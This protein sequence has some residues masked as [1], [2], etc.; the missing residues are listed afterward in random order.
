MHLT[1]HFS[2]GIICG[3]ILSQLTVLSPILFGIIIIGAC[4][5][6]LDIIFKNFA[7][8]LNHRM[9]FTH[10]I[11]PP[12]MIIL[13]GIPIMNVVVI[14]FGIA[15]LTH[16]LADLLDWGT[17]FLFNGKIYGIRILLKKDEYDGVSELLKTEK[18]KKWFFVRRYYGS[19]I[20]LSF[21]IIILIGSSLLLLLIAPQFWY[22]IFGYLIAVIF[23]AME[24]YHIQK[25]L[26]K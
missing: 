4:I 13:I 18:V 1:F 12:V 14:F 19:K 16:V 15:Y 26:K 24:Y 6:D 17:N 23:H 20:M 21:E 7:Q 2:L 25:A 8:N 11:I 9:L 22:F 3:I 5:S 10:S